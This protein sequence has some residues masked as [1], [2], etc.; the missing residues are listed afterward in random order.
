VDPGG[1]D[2]EGDD[3]R[4][5]VWCAQ[6]HAVGLVAAAGVVVADVVGAENLCHQAILMN[7]AADAVTSLNPGPVEVGDIAGQSAQRRGL[8]QGSV[9]PV[10][11]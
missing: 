3:V 5:V 11:L 2:G 1:R 9:G 8:L 10:V 6:V 7:N 4:V